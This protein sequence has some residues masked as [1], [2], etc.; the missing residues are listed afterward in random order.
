M[1]HQS[2]FGSLIVHAVAVI[3]LMHSRKNLVRL[4]DD[5][6]IERRYGT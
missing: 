6:E 3:A 2:L 5:H 4:V 1:R